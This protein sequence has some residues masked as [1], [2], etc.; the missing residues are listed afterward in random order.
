MPKDYDYKGPGV[1]RPHPKKKWVNPD[2]IPVTGPSAGKPW[3]SAG[4]RGAP[5]PVEDPG[6]VE[7]SGGAPGGGGRRGGGRSPLK[8]IAGVIGLVV[9]LVAIALLV[10]FLID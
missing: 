5:P 2:A 10:L 1:T 9:L 3:G 8:L 6:R 4:G 7:P